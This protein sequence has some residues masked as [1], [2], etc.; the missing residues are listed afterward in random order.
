MDGQAKCLHDFKSPVRVLAAFFQKSRDN[1][2]QKCME[3]KAELKRWKVRGA[4]VGKSRDAWRSKAESRQKEIEAL[5]AQVQRQQDQ[6]AEV[7]CQ[8]AADKKK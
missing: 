5:Q 7:T 1:W 6:L 8:A 4:D 3:A 2:K